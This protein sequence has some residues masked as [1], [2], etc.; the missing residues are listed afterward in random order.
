MH[1]KR[2]YFAGEHDGEPLVQIVRPGEQVKTASQILPSVQSFIDRLTPDPRYTYVLV[3]A[4]GYSEFYGSNSNRDWYGHNEH[5]DFNGLLHAPPDFGRDYETDKMQG[6]DWPYGFPSY[7]GATVYAHHK[8]TD[9]Q[10]LGFGDVI[11][12]ATN[13]VMKRVELVER[14]FNEEAQKKGH[15]SILERVAAGERVDVS[16]GCKVPFD[17][18]SICTDWREVKKAWK[19]FNPE[20]HRHPGVAILAYH[21]TIRPI[22]GLAIT[23]KDYCEHMLQIPGQ[24]LPDGRKVYVYNDF[25]RFFD[26]SFVL[27]GADRTARVM[28]HMAASAPDRAAIPFRSQDPGLVRLLENLLSKTSAINIASMEKEVPDGF[29]Q[30]VHADADTATDFSDT[31]SVI[32]G[33]AEDKKLTA[34]K[35]LT[36]LATLGIVASPK[37][38]QTLALTDVPGGEI[39]KKAL[40]ERGVVFDTDVG[41]LDDTFSVGEKFYDAKLTQ[42]FTPMLEER[43][44]FDP[45]L[46]SRLTSFEPKTAGARPLAIRTKMLDK[47]AAQY[48]GYRISVLENAGDLFP[49][50]AAFLGSGGFLAGGGKGIGLAALLLGLGPMIHLLSSHLRSRREEGQQIGTMASFV[51]DNPSFVTITTIGAGL[52]AAMA[53]DKAG[54]LVQAARS[55]ITAARGVL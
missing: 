25:P 11:F 47:L 43:S 2:A 15:T 9:P 24:I 30:A 18:C 46:T 41:G 34:R 4:M 39:I 17:F 50:T 44:G 28:W 35:I 6:R 51:A 3:N 33:G 16:M 32:L 7:Y 27:I 13:P 8:N 55:V 48:N 10:Q 20:H 19:T 5:L 1:I 53:I 26:I 54:G 12:V 49:K 21:K 23:R 45:F 22:R 36:A 37:E 31:L 38:F 29:A 40:D 42:A 14:V 52:R